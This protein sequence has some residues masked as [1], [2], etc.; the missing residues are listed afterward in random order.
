MAKRIKTYEELSQ[1]VELAAKAYAEQCVNELGLVMDDQA[2]QIVSDAAANKRTKISLHI[3]PRTSGDALSLLVSGDPELSSDDMKRI[4]TP[5]VTAIRHS[6][7][8]ALAEANWRLASAPV[9]TYVSGDR[10]CID[11]DAYIERVVKK[12]NGAGPYRTPSNI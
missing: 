12:N 5:I 1:M 4:A 11:V 9:H 6:I 7:E 2:V 3:H 10:L 8:A